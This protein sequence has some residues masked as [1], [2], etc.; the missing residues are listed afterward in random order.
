VP[1]DQAFRDLDDGQQALLLA[2]QRRRLGVCALG[3]STERAI[4]NTPELA[5]DLTRSTGAFR[6]CQQPK[7]EKCR[8]GIRSFFFIHRSQAQEADGQNARTRRLAYEFLHN[9]FGEYLCAEFLLRRVFEIV[10][11]HH[12]DDGSEIGHL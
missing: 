4:N 7:A 9:T 1:Q 2:K 8:F 12:H 10:G 3:C 5:D 11:P 6:I